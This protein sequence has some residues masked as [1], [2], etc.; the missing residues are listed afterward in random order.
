[1]NKRILKSILFSLNLIGIFLFFAYKAPFNKF[2]IKSYYPS[3]IRQT[4]YKIFINN[5]K[6]EQTYVKVYR[7]ISVK[8]TRL[9]LLKSNYEYINICPASGKTSDVNFIKKTLKVTTNSGYK[10]PFSLS[11]NS[12]CLLVKVPYLRN[13][14]YGDTYN[15]V[16]FYKDKTIALKRGG[17][18]EISYPRLKQKPRL[19]S[20]QNI[21]GIPFETVHN[22]YITY[23]IDKNL[24]P[25]VHIYNAG[26]ILKPVKPVIFFSNT[27][28]FLKYN[29]NDIW[30]TGVYMVIGNHRFIKFQE[31]ISGNLNNQILNTIDKLIGFRQVIIPRTDKATGQTV[32]YD[33]IEP[34]PLNVKLSKDGNLMATFSGGI[35]VKIIG[36]AQIDYKPVNIKDI[37]KM[38]LSDYKLNP[39][40]Q[41]YILPSY[42]YWPSDSPE[43]IS[44]ANKLKAKTVLQTLIN[45]INFIKGHIKY[46]DVTDLTNIKRQGALQALKSGQGVCMEFADT[47]I[48][49]LRA[50]KIASR[51][52]LGNVL[53][54]FVDP[55]YKNVGHEWVEVFFPKYGWISV[56]PTLSEKN[57]I[58]I[59]QNLNYFVYFKAAS[60]KDLV[61]LNCLSWSGSC[62]NLE[63]SVS[64]INNINFKSSLLQDVKLFGLNGDTS[65]LNNVNNKFKPNSGIFKYT[66]NSFVY[67][68][69]LQRM[70]NNIN[71]LF[72]HNKFP[73]LN[74]TSAYILFFVLFYILVYLLVLV[75]RKIVQFCILKI[76]LKKIK[77]LPKPSKRI[78]KTVIVTPQV[79]TDLPDDDD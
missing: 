46:N 37:S 28:A 25:E 7:S 35:P 70:F 76:K 63:M 58:V 3:I 24:Y 29:I 50:Q 23:V 74:V 30:A 78:L 20:R 73:A 67:V 31:S 51:A 79:T 56:D 60:V 2:I 33:L 17:I 65:E 38:K 61:Q 34:K 42:P 44:I 36:Y 19:I 11:S 47:L 54:R 5:E 1:M 66:V 32:Y 49:I 9:I 13:L 71:Q 41:R 27:K 18:I 8:T 45:D 55:A 75:V 16:I 62:Q 4:E 6:P 40:L 64:F 14:R 43:I 52:V 69:K 22:I 59:G 12:N 53:N 26:N 48:T 10:L 15:F 68:N 57:N 39:L 72:F 21:N 77:K